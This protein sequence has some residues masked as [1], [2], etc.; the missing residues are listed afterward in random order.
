ML[1]A[2]KEHVAARLTEVY[3]LRILHAAVE[4]NIITETIFKLSL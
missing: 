2:V 3:P 1:L 4:A